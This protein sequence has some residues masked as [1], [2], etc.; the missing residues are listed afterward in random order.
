MIEENNFLSRPRLHELP[1]HVTQTVLALDLDM[2]YCIA[3]A[4]TAFGTVGPAIL[5]EKRV[6]SIV[7]DGVLTLG[8]WNVTHEVNLQC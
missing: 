4:I 5:S 2:P 7:N 8:E 1:V 3:L 6:V